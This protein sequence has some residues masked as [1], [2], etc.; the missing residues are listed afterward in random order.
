MDD[1]RDRL[2]RTEQNHINLKENFASFKSDD[3]GA[4]KR[5]VHSMRGE[6]NTKI[7]DLHELTAAIKDDMTERT[8]GINMLLA[9]W[10]GGFAV[11]LFIG[12]FAAKKFFS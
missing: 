11:L 8:H 12:E 5:E 6:L 4:L 2:A 3:F 1:I 7:D 10:T 9:K